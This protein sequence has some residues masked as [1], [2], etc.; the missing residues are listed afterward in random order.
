MGPSCPPEALTPVGRAL[1][2]A[3]VGV[4]WLAVLLGPV[5]REWWERATDPPGGDEGGPAAGCEVGG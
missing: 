5:L 4:M 3:A 2:L 1:G